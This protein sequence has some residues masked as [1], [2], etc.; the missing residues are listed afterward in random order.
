MGER[1]E[2]DVVRVER[3]GSDPLGELG[4]AFVLGIGDSGEELIV[5][6][7]SADVLRRAAPTA[8]SKCG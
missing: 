8:S 4:M 3:A 2:V 6:G 5:A 1:V 7:D